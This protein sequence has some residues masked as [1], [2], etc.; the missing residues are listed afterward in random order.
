M[1]TRLIA[2]LVILYPDMKPWTAFDSPS[3]ATSIARTVHGVEWLPHSKTGR[4]DQQRM[5]EPL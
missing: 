5:N 4:L 1:M 2:S 3:A